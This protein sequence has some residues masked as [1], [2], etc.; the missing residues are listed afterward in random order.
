MAVSV[1]FEAILC[2][3]FDI[4][5]LQVGALRGYEHANGVALDLWESVYPDVLL[6]ALTDTFSTEAF[7][8][9]SVCYCDGPT[10]M[11]ILIRTTSNRISSLTKPVQSDGKVCAK[12][13]ETHMFTLR[14]RRRSM[15]LSE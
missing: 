9:V 6:L 13:P 11:H 5:D 2:N 3:R 4:L 15:N 12:I 8:R 14:E 10:Y 1:I 7:Y